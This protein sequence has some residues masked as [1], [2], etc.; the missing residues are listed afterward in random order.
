MDIYTQPLIVT[1]KGRRY[2]ITNFIPNHPGGDAILRKHIGTD[3]T[4][5][6]TK[7]SHGFKAYVKLE[8]FRIEE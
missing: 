5:V 4:E 3:I 6:M 2:D 8:K 1:Y 7:S